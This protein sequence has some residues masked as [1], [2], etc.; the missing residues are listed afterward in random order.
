[1]K[2]LL[3]FFLCG[4]SWG[5]ALVQANAN[6]NTRSGTNPLTCSF[7]ST[8]T[9][10]HL[11][12]V[13]FTSVNGSIPA[14]I[15]DNQATGG[16]TYTKLGSGGSCGSQICMSLWA[17]A[18]V[19]SAGTF[20]VSA[21][22]TGTFATIV[23]AEFSGMPST[24]IQDGLAIPSAQST[25]TCVAMN[26]TNSND[27]LL[28]SI[29]VFNGGSTTGVAPFTLAAAFS[30]TGPGI[31]LEYFLPGSSGDFTPS[32][33]NASPTSTQ[34]INAAL[35]VTQD[36]LT[37]PIIQKRTNCF[38]TPNVSGVDNTCTFFSTPKASSKIIVS[39]DAIDPGTVTVTDNQASGGN[40]YTLESSGGTPSTQQILIY[41]ATS[42]TS[43][44]TFTVT[45]AGNG[46]ARRINVSMW[47]VAGLT[48]CTPDKTS[49]NTGT[50]ASTF[51]CG[52]TGSTTVAT[53]WILASVVNLTG[54]GASSVGY[55]ASTG[56]TL[57]SFSNWNSISPQSASEDQ[58][59]STTGSFSPQ[60]TGTVSSGAYACAVAAFKGGPL[61]NMIHHKVTSGD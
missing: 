47:E 32:F 49:N 2:A 35:V 59:T 36:T 54:N 60:F 61:N 45:S 57:D 42:L 41:C 43:S 6:C 48:T 18:N 50:S 44:G 39:V 16:N 40:T 21:A 38:E 22:N 14:A 26:T 7:S 28:S 9:A 29:G 17:S 5:Q 52:T 4:C 34:C 55:T 31:G 11:V 3:L 15:T 10:G 8:P 46:G 23:M 58:F 24:L 25:A 30:G 20:T 1:M 13:G 12:V 53:D 19:K 37:Y 27:L 33:S 51:T 56:F